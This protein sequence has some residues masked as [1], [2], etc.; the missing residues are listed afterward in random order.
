[1]NYVCPLCKIGFKSARGSLIHIRTCQQKCSGYLDPST[2][3]KLL[4][5]YFDSQQ[6]RTECNDTE[7]VCEPLDFLDEESEMVGDNTLIK[8][9]ENHLES[10]FHKWVGTNENEYGPGVELL[11]LLKAAKCPLYLFDSIIEWAKISCNRYNMDFSKCTLTRKSMMKLMTQRLDSN[12]LK[13]EVK[14]VYLPGLQNNVKVVCHDFSQCLYSLL[15]DKTLMNPSNIL[16]ESNLTLDDTQFPEKHI[17]DDINSGLVYKNAKKIYITDDQREKLIPIIM[18]TDKTH[19]DIHGRLCLEPIQFTLGIFNRTTRNNPKAWR[20]LGYVTELLYNGKINTEE[21]MQDYHLIQNV[22]L[23][24]LRE[25]QNKK[26]EWKFINPETNELQ[27]YIMKLPVLYVIGDTDG[28]DKLC[29]RKSCR[30]SIDYLCR[31][32][33]IHRDDLDDGQNSVKYTDIEPIK[34]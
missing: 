6:S 2:I 3:E 9:R 24:S 19:T 33:D 11:V 34:K 12:G 4:N 17:F 32:C 23:N 31:Y 21:K 13:P 20:T 27:G 18:F 10:G 14:N 5:N 30:N 1:M 16:N 7:I 8:Q 22:I 26:F 29:G 15:T 28:H 25:A